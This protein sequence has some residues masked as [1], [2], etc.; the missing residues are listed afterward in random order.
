VPRVS[1]WYPDPT[2]RFEYRYHN[3]RHWTADV[4]TNGRRFVDPLPAPGPQAAQAGTAVPPDVQEG[5]GNGIAVAAMVCGIVAI[6]TAWIPFVGIVGL[7]AG[8]VAL[9]LGI[10]ALVRSR[11]TGRRRGQS[12]AGIVTGAVGLLLGVLGIVFSIVLF[13][14]VQRFED[15]G[16]VNAEVTSC[17]EVDGEIV[18][19]GTV[20]NLSDSERD[21]TVLVH[22][23]PG[24]SERVSVDDVAPGATAEFTARDRQRGGGPDC[25]IESVDGPVPFGLDPTLFED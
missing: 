5:G 9:A 4:A 11:A 24:V 12:I 23:G 3:D 18:A 7:I 6:A 13:R 14:A 17:D 19:N 1:G 21:Y 8:V 10:P 16:P 15:P 20:E 25:R 22:L 2:G